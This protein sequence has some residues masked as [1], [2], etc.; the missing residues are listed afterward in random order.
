MKIECNTVFSIQN[1]AGDSIMAKRSG[2]VKPSKQF[3]VELLD[4]SIIVVSNKFRCRVKEDKDTVERYAE[5]FA[6]Y[7]EAKERGENPSYPFPMIKVWLNGKK[8]VLIAGYHRLDAARKAGLVETFVQVFTGTENEAFMIA[9][10]DND[11][12]GLRLKGGDIKLCIKKTLKRFPDKTAGAIAKELGCNRS[13]V[14]RIENELSPRRQLNAKT[15]KVGADGKI[16]S[17]AKKAKKSTEIVPN[18]PVDD[19]FV[20]QDG[21][22]LTSTVDVTE[23]PGTQVELSMDE[24]INYAIEVLN[25]T[26]NQ[27]QDD[28]ERRS[29]LYKINRWVNHNDARITSRKK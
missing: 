16:R 25:N 19:P 22:S 12:H 9:L 4:L 3:K 14:Y 18:E 21:V 13:Y 10:A 29:L 11:K 2:K 26:L 7:K 15:T 6:E 8:Y 24:K 1:R 20:D 28:K 17:T 5:V 23:A 27:M